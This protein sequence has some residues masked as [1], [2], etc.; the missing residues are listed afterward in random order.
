MGLLGWNMVTWLFLKS[1]Q[2]DYC[3]E[4]AMCLPK[5]ETLRISCLENVWCA[6]SLTST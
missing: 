3:S 2:F 4:S 6:V 5:I 1:H